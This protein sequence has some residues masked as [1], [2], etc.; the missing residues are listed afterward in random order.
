MSKAMTT[1][2][3]YYDIQTT[4]IDQLND[5]ITKTIYKQYI[6]NL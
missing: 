5:Q 2:S 1:P 3:T 6:N 4:V